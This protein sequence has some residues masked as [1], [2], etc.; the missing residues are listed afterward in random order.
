MKNNT[1]SKVT[2]AAVMAAGLSVS[3]LPANAADKPGMEK[4]YGVVKAGKNDCGTAKHSCAGQAKKSGAET[5]W[6]YLP[7][8]T[9]EKLAGG[10]LKK[11]ES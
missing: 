11:D 1:I 7:K 8:G 10:K 2:M 9:C 6:V 5:D 3:T 4:C